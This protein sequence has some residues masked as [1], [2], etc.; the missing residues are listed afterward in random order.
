MIT[1]VVMIKLKDHGDAPE[2]AARLRALPAEV[3]EIRG[4]DVGIDELHGPRAW[5]VVLVSRFDSFATL[6]TYVKHP[7]H[8]EVVAYLDQV[9]ETRASVDFNPAP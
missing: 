2:V 3:P 8:Q 1:H 7:A 4:Y 9:C 5:D 6:A